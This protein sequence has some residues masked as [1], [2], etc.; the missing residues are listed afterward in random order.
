VVEFAFVKARW[1]NVWRTLL[2]EGDSGRENFI[3]TS[4][5][6][7]LFDFSPYC[8]PLIQ[9]F[10]TVARRENIHILQ[11]RFDFSPLYTGLI[12]VIVYI[13]KRR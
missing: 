1:D 2:K 7:P 10:S 5:K 9:K 11:A 6:C 13:G 4:G 3:T 12:V 8:L